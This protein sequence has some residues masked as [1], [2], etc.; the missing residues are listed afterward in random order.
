MKDD[1]EDREV[2]KHRV[3]TLITTEEKEELE[4][5]AWKSGRSVSGYIRYLIIEAIDD[6]L[7]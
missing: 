2:R 3:V 6:R 4:S 7:T 1:D 5:L